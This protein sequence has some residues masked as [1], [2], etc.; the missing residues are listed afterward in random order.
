MDKCV[1]I[2]VGFLLVHFNCGHIVNK[3]NGNIVN[4][5]QNIFIFELEEILVTC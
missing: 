3:L 1:K 2:T 5:L 4:K